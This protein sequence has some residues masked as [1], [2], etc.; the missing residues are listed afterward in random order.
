MELHNYLFYLFFKFF[1]SLG[2]KDIPE[3]KAIVVLSLWDCFYLLIPY[4]LIRYVTGKDL[5]V[6]KWI[7]GCLYIAIALTY[8][9]LFIYNK[10]YLRIYRKF[11]R[12]R[13]FNNKYGAVIIALYLLL[14]FV[15]MIIFTFT[16]WK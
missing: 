6:P 9:F 14:P 3:S 7:I 5:L 4:G 12:E 16:I 11:E 13:D 8:F 2:R 15:F 1:I 10:R